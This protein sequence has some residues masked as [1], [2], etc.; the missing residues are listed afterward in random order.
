[1]DAP[2]GKID[3]FDGDPFK[4]SDPFASDYFLRQSCTD[5]FATSG[6]DPCSAPSNG[7]NA[8]VEILKHNDPFAPGGTVLIAA[9]DSTTDLFA[10]IFRNKSF[11]DGFAD[12]STLSKG[13]GENPFSSAMLS[14]VSSVSFLKMLLR[15]H[16]SRMKM[17]PPALPP[18]TGTP[19]RPCLPPPGKRLVNK[20]DSSVPFKMNDSFNPFFLRCDTLK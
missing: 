6:T 4:G 12:L 5:R 17:Y 13:N 16:Q 18:K 19:T 1:M 10:S 14:T 3:P 7:N 2:F 9:S 20:L 11:G 15:K 8:L